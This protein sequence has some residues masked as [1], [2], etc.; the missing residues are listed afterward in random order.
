M[1][2]PVIL[3]D[4]GAA[5]ENVIPAGRSGDFTGWVVPP[6]DSAALAAAIGAALALSPAARAALGERARAHATAQFALEKMQWA[7]LAIYD[8]L[9]GSELAAKLR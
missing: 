1:G 5:P 8:E 9:L 3:T 4:V 6:A 2:C 7:T